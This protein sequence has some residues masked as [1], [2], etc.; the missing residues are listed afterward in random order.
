MSKAQHTNR[1]IDSNDPYLLLHAH[2]P[3]DWY[4]WG[5][6]ALE[7]AKREKKPIFLSVGYSTCY[8]CHV[9]EETIYSQQEF[10]DLMNEWFVNIKVDREQR[11]DID[12]LYMAATQAMTGRGGWPNNVF[13][14]P[15]L[16]PFFAGSYFPPHDDASGRP[17]FDSIL[18]SIH[19][20]WVQDPQRI[21]EK[22]EKMIAALRDQHAPPATASEPINSRALFEQALAAWVKRADSKRGGFGAVKGPRFPQQPVL[23]MLMADPGRIDI[24][25]RTLDAMAAGGIYDHLA[26]GFHRYATEPTWS[27]PHFEKMLYDNAQLLAIYAEAFKLTADPHYRIVATELADYL[28]KQ[29]MAPEGGFYTAEDATVNGKEGLSY[30]WTRRE[31][32]AVL[33]DEVATRFFGAYDLTPMPDQQNAQAAAQTPGDI[34][35]VLRRR[36]P[37]DEARDLNAYTPWRKHLLD[38]RNRRLQPARDEKVVVAL[39]G[40]A[41]QAF[42]RAGQS[43]AMPQY[44]EAARRS[45]EHL[46]RVAYQNDELRHEIFNGR[47]Q[48]DAFL[49]DYALLGLGFL[50]LFDATA[51]TKWRQRAG[52]LADDLLARF[53]RVDGS[54][55]TTIAE[56]DLPMAPPEDGDNIYPS[57]SSAAVDLLLRLQRSAGTTRYLEAAREIVE[58]LDHRIEDS[59]ESWPAMLLA[60]DEHAFVPSADAVSV[61]LTTEA[62]VRAS[63]AV[64]FRA[65]RDEVVVTLQIKD[66]FHVNANPATYDYL[67]ATG[68][69]FA[70]LTPTEVLYPA[71]KLFKPAFAPA[72]LKVYEGTVSLEA[73]FPKGA[74]G[75]NTAINAVVLTQACNS[76]ICLPPGKLTVTLPGR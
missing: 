7:K 76:E 13:L 14:T 19:A 30:L 45:A 25:T 1:L 35:G 74:I 38:V 50:D 65:D 9:A 62:V 36:L 18:R 28:T 57:G 47:A 15:D 66:G 53:Q 46:W 11:P 26:G 55:A 75:T 44:V 41:I 59:P 24:L 8:W 71:A 51:D 54:L 33:G 20:S 64:K 3:V 63:A 6:E 23:V 60:L 58:R 5:P 56:K 43:L 12:R 67:I 61:P 42:A 21:V 40:L 72:G 37:I 39:N 2:N 69:T 16:K 27:I 34:P 52:Q 32:V 10:A 68:V 4:P 49:D 73:S 17:G 70:G 31:I 48:T 29:M 22:A